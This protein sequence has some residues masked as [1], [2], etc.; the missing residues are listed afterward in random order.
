MFSSSFVSLGADDSVDEGPVIE[1]DQTEERDVD[2]KTLPSEKEDYVCTTN[3]ETNEV[4]V[5]LNDDD[6]SAECLTQCKA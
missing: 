2:V 1:Q 3:N 4:D 5:V 6:R